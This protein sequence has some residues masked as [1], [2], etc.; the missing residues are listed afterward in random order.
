M[1]IINVITIQLEAHFVGSW[2]RKQIELRTFA[3]LDDQDL[4]GTKASE[5]AFEESIM[6]LAN[7]NEEIDI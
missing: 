6:K 5:A 7:E 1:T 2:K 3:N 4:S